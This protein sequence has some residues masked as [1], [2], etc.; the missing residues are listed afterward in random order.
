MLML[1]FIIALAGVFAVIVI[2]RYLARKKLLHAENKRKFIHI[3]SGLYIALW[4]W[5]L[6]WR[7][8]QLAGL[9]MLAVIVINRRLKVIDYM[10]GTK[11][12][13][14]GDIFFALA[15]LLCALLTTNKYFF[16]LA[17][18]IMGLGDGMAAVVGKRYGKNWKYKSLGQ[19][20]TFVGTLTFWF[21]TLLIL[22]FSM[23]FIA[24]Y[25]SAAS[26]S[27]I[28]LLLPPALT[29]IENFAVYGADNLAI[30]LITILALSIA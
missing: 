4:P 24:E 7:Q 3:F 26:Y 27:L 30:P 6:S 8:I 19:N 16:M 13:S 18:L 12:L 1:S 17:I 11:R 15:V 29:L 22:G 25:T 2:D 5:L 10:S 20:K 21:I 14:Y 28:L 23:P 9:M